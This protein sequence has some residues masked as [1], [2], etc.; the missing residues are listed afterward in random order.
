MLNTTILT[1]HD[2]ANFTGSQQ[3]YKN[4]F[5]TLCYTEGVRYVAQQAG[6]YW[7]LEQIAFLQA[8]LNETHLREFQLWILTLRSG[9]GLPPT[10]D[11]L[12]IAP[13]PHHDAILTCWADTPDSWH[14]WQNS[15]LLKMTCDIALTDFPLTQIKFYLCDTQIGPQVK[16]LLMLPSEY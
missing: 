6:A 4:G 15:P 1:Y 14:D 11:K 9:K 13:K 10:N 8:Q 12:Q 2:L 3:V 7:L 5:D 16:P